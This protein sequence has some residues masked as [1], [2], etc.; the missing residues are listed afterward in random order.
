MN[1]QIFHTLLLL[2]AA[3]GWLPGQVITTEDARAGLIEGMRKTISNVEQPRADFSR[4]PSPFNP[5]DEEVVAEPDTIPEEAP[6]RI[7]RSSERLDDMVAL[8][9]I[10]HSFKPLGSLVM[11][12]RGVLQLS[13]NRTIAEG[14]SFNAK[15]QGQTYKV[16]LSEVTAR[17]YKLS[18]GSAEVEKNFIKTGATN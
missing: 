15:I 11:G 9:I 6:I 16:T 12:D 3:T 14:A 2:G 18:L 10:S 7:V 17:S 1:K 8:R 13:D 4:V 5:P